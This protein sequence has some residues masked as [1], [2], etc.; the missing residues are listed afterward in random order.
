MAIDWSKASQIALLSLTEAA[1][2]APQIGSQDHFTTASDALDAAATVASRVIT[3]PTQLTEAKAA[4]GAAS[5]LLAL[6]GVF[7]GHKKT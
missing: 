7:F 4:Y 3:D 2:V 6:F 1:S 5:L